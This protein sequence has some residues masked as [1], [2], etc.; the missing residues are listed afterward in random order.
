[1]LNRPLSYF[2]SYYTHNA[3]AYSDHRRVGEQA[4]A[5]IMATGELRA[6]APKFVL[7]SSKV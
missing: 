1:M 4:G 3:E 7:W 5:Y 6:A 2:I